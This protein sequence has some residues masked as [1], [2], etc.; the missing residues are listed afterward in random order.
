[1]RAQLLSYLTTATSTATVK[2]VSELPWNTAGE[3]LYLKNMKRFYLDKEQ[4]AESV[5]IAVLPGSNDVMQNA[6]TVRGYFSVDAKN[7]PAGLDAAV[8]TILNAKNQVGIGNF[9][10]E[11]DYTT[12]IQDDVLIYNIEYR[13]NTTP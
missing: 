3:P 13:I 5:M 11:S 12:E 9:G 10:I 8:A 1:M 2:T 4:K 6:T 7:Q